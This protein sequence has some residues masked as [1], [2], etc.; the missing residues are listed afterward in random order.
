M[1]KSDC[2]I[3]Y[4]LINFFNNNINFLPNDV[5][6]NGRANGDEQLI[7]ISTISI[8]SF[9]SGCSGSTEEVLGVPITKN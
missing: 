8:D 4:N 9:I 5:L 2:T 6:S 1:V 7:F 3:I